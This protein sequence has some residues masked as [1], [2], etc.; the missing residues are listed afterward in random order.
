MRRSLLVGSRAWDRR[1]YSLDSLLNSKSLPFN[2]SED[3]GSHA[4]L[5]GLKNDPIKD[6][7]FG[8]NQEENASDYTDPHISED[9]YAD[10]CQVSQQE[11]HGDG[12]IAVSDKS[13]ENAQSPASNLSDKID[14]AWTGTDVESSQASP[15]SQVNQPVDTLP[16]KRLMAPAR[17]YS[18]DSAMRIHEK[19]HRGF[20]P[21]YLSAVRSFHASGEYRNMLRDPTSYVVRTYSQISP[22]DANFRPSFISSASHLPGEGPRLLLPQAGLSDLVVA[23]YDDE[24]TSVISYALSSKEYNDWVSD[25]LSQHDGSWVGKDINREDSTAS[26]FLTWQ[27]LG[28]LDLDYINYGNYGSEDATSRSM[29][30]ADPKRSPH[31]QISFD[32]D[33]SCAGGKAKF[34]VTCY[35]AKQFDMLLKKCCPSKV[36]F[37]CSLSRCRRWSAQG[38]KSNVY[39]AKSMDE[40]FIIKQVTKTE[41][42]SFQ[43]FA[44]Q[45]FK[46]LNDSLDSGSP[47]CLAK[48]FGIFQVS[49]IFLHLLTPDKSCLDVGR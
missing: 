42:E 36:D 12:E 21:S 49:T 15:I 25:K 8:T 27:S 13:S 37:V 31:L 18:F 32:D 48:I 9:S 10:S 17:V 22:F 46:Y 44:P 16:L 5:K 1:L 30:F 14:S 7:K 39:F 33:S 4:T 28:S 35:F 6:F 23:V 3:M 40:R 11:S 20:A 26:T 24:P 34:S 2:A 47:T 41:L 45:Y 29:L 43:E 19:V 38:G